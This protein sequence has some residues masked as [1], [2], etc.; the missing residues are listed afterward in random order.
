MRESKSRAL[1]LGYT[2]MFEAFLL[3]EKAGADAPALATS[4]SGVGNGARTHDTRNHN[5]V[6]CQ[7]SYTHHMKLVRLK[8][9][10]AWSLDNP[11]NMPVAYFPF[12]VPPA[13]GEALPKPMRGVAEWHAWRD[14]NP[15]PT[16]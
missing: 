3:V 15:R 11:E 7:L 8:R 5:P 16:A 2:P 10:H 1:P 9:W 12:K 13:E 6:L 14:S 4:N